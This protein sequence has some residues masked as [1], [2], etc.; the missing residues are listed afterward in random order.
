VVIQ[1]TKSA[2]IVEGEPFIVTYKIIN[3][4]DATATKI[5]VA[6]R[7][8][9]N[10]LCCPVLPDYFLFLCVYSFELKENVNAEGTV[11]FSVDELPPDS[12]TTYNVTVAPKLHGMYESTR[13]RVRYNTGM[14]IDD[15]EDDVR[16]VSIVHWR[17]CRLCDITRFVEPVIAHPSAVS[18]SYPKQNTSVLLPASSKNGSFSPCWLSELPLGLTLS[19]IKPSVSTTHGLVTTGRISKY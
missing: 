5:D 14:H 19:G 10:R 9:P 2:H 4:G 17:E 13:A 8:D 12:T 3:N 6:D 16:F 7:Y 11:M 18:R 1:A 15:V